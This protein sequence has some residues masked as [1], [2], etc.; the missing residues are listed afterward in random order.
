MPHIFPALPDSS[1]FAAFTGSLDGY[2]KTL[3]HILTITFDIDV[4][5]VTA[6]RRNK[7]VATEAC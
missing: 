1:L 7:N 2:Y 3:N 6:L 5:S 4:E